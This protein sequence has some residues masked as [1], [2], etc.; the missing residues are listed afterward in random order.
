[1]IVFPSVPG[2][3]IV[4]SAPTAKGATLVVEARRKGSPFFHGRRV[5]R[6]RLPDQAAYSAA[7][8]FSHAADPTYLPEGPPIAA[9]VRSVGAGF[10]FSPEQP[11]QARATA[12]AIAKAEVRS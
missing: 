3:E 1:V 9:R 6:C 12:N 8:H 5:V 4:P 10:G 2:P 7:W 11:A